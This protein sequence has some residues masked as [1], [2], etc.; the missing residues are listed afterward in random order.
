MATARVTYAAKLGLFCHTCLLAACI[1]SD[2]PDQVYCSAP[3]AFRI[4]EITGPVTNAE[5]LA[6]AFDLDD[7]GRADNSAGMVMAALESYFADA[8]DFGATASAHVMSDVTW[9]LTLQH[10]SDGSVRYSLGDVPVSSLFDGLGTFAD[11]GLQ[12]SVA[13]AF[14]LDEVSGGVVGDIGFAIR[15][16]PAF[17][18]ITAAMTPFLDELAATQSQVAQQYDTNRD[19]TITL[20]EVRTN[21][22]TQSLLQSD[23]TID[24]EPAL[25][26]A[27]RIRA[28]R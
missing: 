21:S 7:D 5:A 27:L 18:A 2:E 4:V 28:G 6:Q 8:I 11:P 15:A 24:D 14:R 25:S 22:L 23:I 19:G 20:D 3:D 13:S 17:D 12:P 26:F 16:Q 10:C 1:P 9:E